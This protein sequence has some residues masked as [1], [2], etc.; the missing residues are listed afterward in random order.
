[1]LTQEAVRTQPQTKLGNFSPP[2]TFSFQTRID[3]EESWPVIEV[4]SSKTLPTEDDIPLET[5]WHRAEINLLIESVRCMWQQR[6]DYY[7]GGNMF[8]YYSQQQVRYKDYRGPD[9][10]LVKDVDGTKERESWMVWEEQGRYPDVIIELLSPSTAL[11]DKTTKKYLYERTFHTT[12][13]YCY[14]PSI[15]ELQGWRLEQGWYKAITPDAQKRLWSDVLQV[16]LGKW[17]GSYLETPDIWLRFFDKQDKV[18]PIFAEVE[19]QH[20]E[21]ESQRAEVESQRAEVESQRAEAESK[22][23]ESESQRAEAAESELARLREE[24]AHLRGK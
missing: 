20:A 11:T 4:P 2:E 9:F 18:V 5:P 6:T 17:S 22:R 8:I 16:W 23:A 24:L 13:Y 12:E 3:V 10:F 21:S 15:D 14:D 19:S 1:M 7:V